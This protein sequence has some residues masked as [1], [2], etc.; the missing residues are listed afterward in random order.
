M[1][2]GVGYKGKSG[3]SKGAMAIDI[4]SGNTESGSVNADER[5]NPWGEGSKKNPTNSS[6]TT[7]P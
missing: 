4:N 3:A 5:Y 6:Y 7:G 2:K 1:P